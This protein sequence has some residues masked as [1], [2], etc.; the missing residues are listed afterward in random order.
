MFT[1]N[2][3]AQVDDSKVDTLLGKF[4][5][6]RADKYLNQAPTAPWDTRFI[7]T[8]QTSPMQTYHMELIRPANGGTPYAVYNGQAFEVAGDLLDALDAD[9]HKT[10]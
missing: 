5:P 3:K 2:A 7:L 10:P 8:L 6:F 9:F 4:S 1:D